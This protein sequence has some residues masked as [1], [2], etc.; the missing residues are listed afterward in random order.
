MNAMILEATNTTAKLVLDPTKNIFEISGES[1]PENTGKYFNPVVEWLN[2]YQNVLYFQ[3]SNYG[4]SPKVSFKFSFDYFNSTSAKY[5][6]D[7][8]TILEKYVSN[9]YEAEAIWVYDA[10]DIDMK[11]SGEEFAI[12][13][14]KLPFTYQ[15][16]ND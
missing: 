6:A 8:L 15:P 12:L 4:K 13:V 16:I 14:P 2:G 1:R 7:M 3:K 10:M 11:E 9:G 5:I